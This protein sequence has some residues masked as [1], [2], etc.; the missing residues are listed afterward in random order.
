[1]LTPFDD[2][3]NMQITV[4]G[5]GVGERGAWFCAGAIAP[6]AKKIASATRAVDGSSG[7][8]IRPVDLKPVWGTE[9]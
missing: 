5:A 7:F 1:M 2:G 4:S 8:R 9:E 6:S 3:F